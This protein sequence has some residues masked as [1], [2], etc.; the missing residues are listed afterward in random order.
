MAKAQKTVT[1]LRGT[2]VE[3]VSYAH[4]DE[5]TCDELTANLLINIKKAVPADPKKAS[6]ATPPADKK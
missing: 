4:G 1:I 6:K 3:G 2:R 5:C